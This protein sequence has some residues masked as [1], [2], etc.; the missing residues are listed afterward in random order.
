MDAGADQTSQSFHKPNHVLF[1]L[2]VT[3]YHRYF[4]AKTNQSKVDAVRS[5]R[6]HGSP[7]ENRVDVLTHFVENVEMYS[8][9]KQV[10]LVAKIKANLNIEVAD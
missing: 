10:V 2:N 1:L 8:N 3:K 7:H 6:T 4:V 5:D 9:T